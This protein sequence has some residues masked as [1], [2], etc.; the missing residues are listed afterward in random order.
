MKK[1]VLLIHTNENKLNFN[2]RKLPAKVIIRYRD[3]L[4]LSNSDLV[5]YLLSTIDKLTNLDPHS[6]ATPPCGEDLLVIAI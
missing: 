5:W 6:N 4:L 3:R 1:T 2:P